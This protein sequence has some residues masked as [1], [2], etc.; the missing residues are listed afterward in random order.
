K[1]VAGYI[2]LRG[3]AA[4]NLQPITDTPLQVTTFLDKVAAGARDGYALQAID[5]AGNPSHAAAGGGGSGRRRPALVRAPR[6]ALMAAMERL[7]RIDKDGAARYAIEQGGEL[8]EVTGDMFGARTTGAAV[9]G[10]VAAA[11][12]LAPVTPSKIVCVG[13]NYKDH[14]AEQNK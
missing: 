6:E 2:V 1:D 8:R 10:G 5:T 7:Y 4:D 9:Q 13:L 14:A 12:L 11:R 3:T